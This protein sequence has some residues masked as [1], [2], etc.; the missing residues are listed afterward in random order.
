MNPADGISKIVD[1][2]TGLDTDVPGHVYLLE[3]ILA[4]P[5]VQ[6][7]LC[8]WGRATPQGIKTVVQLMAH[9]RRKGM[10]GRFVTCSVKY[11]SGKPT[12]PAG[13]DK[14]FWDNLVM[15]VRGNLFIAIAIRDPRH[16]DEKGKAK[17]LPGREIPLV[18]A[19]K[20]LAWGAGFDYLETR[21]N[22]RS[23]AWALGMWLKSRTPE[24]TKA[25]LLVVR[26][27]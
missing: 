5:E 4:F 2:E 19:A 10:L 23:L 15:T 7:T 26:A 24:E 8:H 9:A 1:P 20:F 12:C 3:S 22:L 13:H 25:G 18:N 17:E 21:A 27:N 14:E 16:M 11:P 6:H